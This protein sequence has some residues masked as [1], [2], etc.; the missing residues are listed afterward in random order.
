MI[1][2]QERLKNVPL[3]PGVYL[4]KDDK[5]QV[6]YVGKAKRLRNRLRSYFQS[7]QRLEPKVRALMNR[8]KDFDYIVTETEVDALVLENNLIK[9][10]KPRY[11]IQLR[12][13]KTY[14]YLKI[15]WEEDFPR[16]SITREKR[17]AS[18]RYFG[19]YPNVTVLRDNLKLLRR[20]FPLR[21]CKHMPVNRRPC[22]NYSI[23]RCLAPCSGRISPEE[24]RARVEDLLS[25]LQGDALK[26][27]KAREKEM[28][29]AAAN[30]E[31]ER[32]ARLR[33]QVQALKELAEEQKINT[34][35]PFDLDLI[36]MISGEKENLVLVFKI[37]SG[38]I[39]AKETFWLKRSVNEPEEEVLSF[40]IRHY[41][42]NGQDIP[43]EILVNLKPDDPGLLEDLLSAQS[44]RKVRLFVPQRGEKK[45][46]MDMLL[47]NA[48]VL[49]EEKKQ[50]DK[51]SLEK[52]KHLAEV[53]G[54]DNLPMRIECYD[55]SHL[56]GQ[57]TVA[58]MVVFTGGKPDKKA[59]RRFKIKNDQNNDFAALSEALSRRFEEARRENPSFLPEPDLILI[60]GGLGQVNTVKRIL[61][62]KGIDIAL[63][64]LAKKHEEIYRPGISEPLRLSRRDEGLKI[65]QQARDEAHRFAIEYNR[66]RRSSRISRS[67]LDEIPGIGPQRKKALLQKFG[68]L[69]EIKKASWQELR[70]TPGFNRA[71]ADNLYR[72]LHPEE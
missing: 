45:R 2:M 6:I 72:F 68:S 11:N 59:Y 32:A 51:K 69:A 13:D 31:F 17:N 43:E 24:Y 5:G 56:A 48:C 57:E 30:L 4:F 52:L 12:D 25:F 10:Y 70:D 54:M 58:S 42:D 27:I 67:L 16:I 22:L 64:S 20:I 8:V 39:S 7:P 9:A 19:P 29:D 3:Q 26:F 47:E 65:L 21:T 23:G 34:E 71:A 33:D 62:A 46:L 14:P 50:E 61:D 49:W 63:F 40:F 1:S 44:G 41:Y 36:G 28:Q 55:I 53:L 15:S 66:Q 37:R 18:S 38:Q 60:D 35:S